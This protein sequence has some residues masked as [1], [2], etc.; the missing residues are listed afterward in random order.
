MINNQLDREDL[1]KEVRN[2]YMRNYRK[3]M[4]EEQ[5]ENRREYQRRWRQENQD[6]VKQN[7]ENYWLRKAEAIKNAK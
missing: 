3:T 7:Q 4:T 6:K 5:K 2:A 1:V